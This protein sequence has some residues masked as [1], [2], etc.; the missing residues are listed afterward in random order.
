M[1]LLTKRHGIEHY[2][3]YISF[4]DSSSEHWLK[5]EAWS[6]E[7]LEVNLFKTIYKYDLSN[8]GLMDQFRALKK[9]KGV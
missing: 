6:I 8:L 9:Q 3:L 2:T 1:K 4:V 7:Q 5:L